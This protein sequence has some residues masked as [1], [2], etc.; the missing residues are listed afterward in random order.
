M[1]KSRKN[2]ILFF[3][4]WGRQQSVVDKQKEICI[5]FQLNLAT[6]D[7]L[8][9]PRQKTDAFSAISPSFSILANSID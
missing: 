2:P 5:D 9:S 6:K 8:Q 7:E 3:L 1:S 4:L